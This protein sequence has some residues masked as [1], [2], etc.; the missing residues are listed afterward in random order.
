MKK[1]FHIAYIV[2]HYPHKAFNDDGGLGTSVFNLVERIRKENHRVSVFVYGQKSDFVIEEEN[3]TIYS[4]EDIEERLFKFYFH[5]KKIE[6]F[7]KEKIKNH[8]ID[9]I[10]APDWTGITAL[11]RFSIPL[12]IRFH[13]SDTYFCHL[14]KR[15][16]KFRNFWFEK[17]AVRNAD[18]Y[19]APTDFAG[20]LSK[21]LFGIQNRKVK[22]IHYGLALEKFQNTTPE[23]FEKGLILYIGTIIR[24]KGVLE[25][26]AIFH[27][28]L[29]QHPDA[30]LVLI[31]G[32]AYDVK[33][34]S[35]ST[36]K[37]VRD[38][39][40]TDG[41]KV[42]YL[43]KIPYHEVQE[44]IK[45]AHVCVFPTFAETLGMVTIESMA[46]QKPVINSNIGWSQELMDDGVSG[47]LV[48]PHNHQ[49]YAQRISELLENDDLYEAIGRA[50]RTE[51]ERNF[52]IEKIVQLNIEFYANV[53]RDF[54]N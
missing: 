33:T 26:P 27:N 45:K 51:V 36:W 52:D 24:K 18:A 1:P 35:D 2:S 22:T 30:K 6:R 7:I 41:E 13:G 29:Q 32:D 54:S 9:L 38:Q 47:Y 28:V 46:L 4:I 14:E 11:M 43:G 8:K 49:L 44:Y 5:R 17:N 15:K 21:Q 31:G 39:L 19:I 37:L 23:S 50:A 53:I 20:N 34:H 25:L 12:V 48:H 42:S 10:E 40:G 3:L 16:Q